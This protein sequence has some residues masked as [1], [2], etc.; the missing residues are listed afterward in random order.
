MEMVKLCSYFLLIKCL[1]S[2]AWPER[3]LGK[4]KVA[5]SIPAQGFL[6]RPKESQF[7]LLGGHVNAKVILPESVRIL[8]KSVRT[9]GSQ[10]DWVGYKQYLAKNFSKTT[11][12][13]RLSYSIKYYKVLTIGDASEIMVLSFDKRIHIMKA[14]ATFS[15]FLGCYDQWKKIVEKYQLRWAD[16]GNGAG[17]AK[18]LEVFQNIYGKNNFTEMISQLKVSYSRLDEKYS[19]VLLYC[20]LTGLRPAE[21]CSSLCLLKERKEDYLAKDNKLLEHFRF[22]S[23][24]LRRTKN[25]Y[26]S[27]VSESL[28]EL[29]AHSSPV[30]YNSLR[31]ALRRK[32]IKMNVSICRKI[33]ATFLRNQGVEQEMID[34]LQG[35]IPKSVF[36]RHYYRPDMSKFDD[37]REKLTKLHEIIVR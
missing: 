28:L 27:I 6:F 26:I 35:R 10:I 23:V 11:A 31:L 4:A 1:G 19:S 15:K 3:C 14:L 30:S 20:T 5:G 12:K 33:F 25:A 7:E 22:P 34:L 8:P 18:G 37:I 16:S 36:V 17:S 29:G 32:Q 24:F 2:S 9:N 21:A 13:A